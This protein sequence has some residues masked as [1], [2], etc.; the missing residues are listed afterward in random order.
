MHGEYQAWMGALAH[1]K[2]HAVRAA[3]G[4]DNGVQPDPCQAKA[5]STLAVRMP[6]RGR[7]LVGRRR[8]GPEGAV[9]ESVNWP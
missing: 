3:A 5:K 7:V 6:V 8:H 1:S 4:A 2:G 9:P